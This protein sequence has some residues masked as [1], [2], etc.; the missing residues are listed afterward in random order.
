MA[1]INYRSK[2]LVGKS[3]EEDM[4]EANIFGNQERNHI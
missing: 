4:N 2:D 3:I 1:R